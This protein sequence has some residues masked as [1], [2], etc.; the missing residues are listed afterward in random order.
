MDGDGDMD[1]ISASINLWL[2]S[3]WCKFLDTWYEILVWDPSWTAIA[4][5]ATSADGADQDRSVIAIAANN[6]DGDGDMDIVSA[7]ASD[8]LPLQ[9]EN[10]DGQ[11]LLGLKV[12]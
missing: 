11:I 4:D 6:M 1:I 12:L 7:S 3:L 9:F 5:I 2:Y 10:I 8:N